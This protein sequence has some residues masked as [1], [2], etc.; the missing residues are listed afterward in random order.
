MTI[1]S[2]QF[3]SSGSITDTVI[4]AEDP[5]YGIY[6]TGVTVDPATTVLYTGFVCTQISFTQVSCSITILDDGNLV[7]SSH[8]I[9]GNVASLTRN[10]YVIDTIPPTMSIVDDVF[11]GPSTGDTIVVTASDDMVLKT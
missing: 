2:P 4:E 11:A 9:A 3:V 10:G 8:D 6:A 5:S 1:T 7:I